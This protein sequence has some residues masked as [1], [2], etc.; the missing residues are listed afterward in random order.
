LVRPNLKTLKFAKK[1]RRN[2]G[3]NL[4]DQHIQNQFGLSIKFFIKKILK[5]ERN[6]D[7]E[8]NKKIICTTFLIRISHYL[9]RF[10]YKIF[11]YGF[12]ILSRKSGFYYLIGVFSLNH[13]ICLYI[14]TLLLPYYSLN[15]TCMP[16]L[17]ILGYR[18]TSWYLMGS[19]LFE[20]KVD[21]H[22]LIANG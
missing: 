14:G 22:S 16:I 21:A 11:P 9:D 3:S 20:V 17:N 18:F 2:S 8:S 13:Y 5:N 7:Y 10:V 12:N 6:F 19:I 15:D 1:T 4:I